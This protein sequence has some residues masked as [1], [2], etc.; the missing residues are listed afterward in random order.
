MQLN[1]MQ[2]KSTSDLSPNLFQTQC[3]CSSLDPMNK[4]GPLS[5]LVDREQPVDILTLTESLPSERFDD[6]FASCSLSRK[7][8]SYPLLIFL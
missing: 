4:G 6:F 3:C 1:K 8:D 7:R 5:L 2:T